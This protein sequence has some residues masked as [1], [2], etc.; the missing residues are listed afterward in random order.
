ML[1]ADFDTT[2]LENTEKEGTGSEWEK[3]AT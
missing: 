1:G 3:E 2:A